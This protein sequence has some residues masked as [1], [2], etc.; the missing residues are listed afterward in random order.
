MISDFTRNAIPQLVDHEFEYSK[1]NHEVRFASLHEAESVI[2]EELEELEENVKSCRSVFDDIHTLL[3]QVGTCCSE[4]KSDAV[5]LR[6][7][8]CEAAQEAIQLAAM[9]E[10]LFEWNN[11]EEAKERD[12]KMASK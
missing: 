11:Y 1:Q 10:K 2:R 8:A 5:A 3:R 7:I 4:M 6:T 12:R 9:G